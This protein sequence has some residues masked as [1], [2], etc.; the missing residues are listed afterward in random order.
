LWKGTLDGNIRIE[1][2]KQTSK[3]KSN[4]DLVQSLDAL[5]A[6]GIVTTEEYE[7]L[8]K[9]INELPSNE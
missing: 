5:M 3:T 8:S 9:R 7:D 4:S 6:N 2:G 1:L